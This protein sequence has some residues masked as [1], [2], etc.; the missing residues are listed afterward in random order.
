[1]K[2][3]RSIPFFIVAIVLVGCGGQHDKA[4]HDM[5][6]RYGEQNDALVQQFMEITPGDGQWNWIS[7]FDG[8]GGK[9]HWN[10]FARLHGRYKLKMQFD[11]EIN[12]RRRDFKR[13]SEPRFYVLEVIEVEVP[14]SPQYGIGCKF[15]DSFTFGLDDWKTL[16]KNKGDFSS[17]GIELKK[18]SPVDNFDRVWQ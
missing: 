4:G 2:N 16:V 17:I 7:Y 13:I 1:M 5:T 14:S 10:S 11:I 6:V 3:V 9:P 15:G 18:D 8:Y 12:Y